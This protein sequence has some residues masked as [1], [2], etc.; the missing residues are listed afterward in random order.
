MM[1]GYWKEMSQKCLGYAAPGTH[2]NQRYCLYKRIAD[3]LKAGE[4]VQGIAWRYNGVSPTGQCWSGINKFNQP[5]DSCKYGEKVMGLYAK[6]LKK[7]K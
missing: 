7:Y 6:Y 1:P 2:T 3:K 4:T 5:F